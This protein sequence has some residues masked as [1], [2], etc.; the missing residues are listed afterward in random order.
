MRLVW[1]VMVLSMVGCG[2]GG[3]PD[4]PDGGREDGGVEDAGEG[5]FCQ[6]GANGCGCFTGR[7]PVCDDPGAMC[8][9]GECVDCEAEPARCMTPPTCGGAELCAR[10]IDECGTDITQEACEGFYDESTTTCGDL[11]GYTRC[12]C[13][14]IEEPTCDDYFSCG[15]TCFEDW[16]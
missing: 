4:G 3:T 15:M 9:E 11:D 1:L 2:D 5:M 14:C 12:N 10:T 6:L 8:V 7:T 16:C 13:R